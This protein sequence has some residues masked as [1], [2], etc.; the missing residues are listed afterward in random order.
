LLRQCFIQREGRAL[1]ESNFAFLGIA[2]FALYTMRLPHPG[3]KNLEK[4]LLYNLVYHVI[5]FMFNHPGIFHAD[6]FFD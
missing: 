3:R 6:F 1:P 2:V 4:T 5:S